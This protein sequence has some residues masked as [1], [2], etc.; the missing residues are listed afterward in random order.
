[1]K[2]LFDSELFICFISLNMDS[3]YNTLARV[4]GVGWD[5]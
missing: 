3:D 1:M 2:C 5:M 4:G